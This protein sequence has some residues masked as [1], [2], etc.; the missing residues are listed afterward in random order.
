MAT[1]GLGISNKKIIP[2]KT[3]YTEQ[4]V[5]SDGI[6]AVPRNRKL[7]EFRSEPFRGRENNSEFSSVEQKKKQTLGIPFRILQWRRKQ[8]RFPFRGPK[9]EENPRN[10]VPN[11]SAEEKATQSKT[12]TRQQNAACSVKLIFF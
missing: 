1:L 4:M 3:E 10:S 12:Q 2:R 7:S 6:T 5:I 9:I 8:H 11:H